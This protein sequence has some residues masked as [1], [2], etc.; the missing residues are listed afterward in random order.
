M[1]VGTFQYS[2]YG[3]LHGMEDPNSRRMS[4]SVVSPGTTNDVWKRVMPYIA[5][6]YHQICYNNWICRLCLNVWYRDSYARYWKKC[7][8]PSSC[9]ICNWF[10][11]PQLANQDRYHHNRCNSCLHGGW[12]GGE[13]VRVCSQVSAVSPT[14]TIL[15]ICRYLSQNHYRAQQNDTWWIILPSQLKSQIITKTNGCME[16]DSDESHYGIPFIILS[17]DTTW[18]HQAMLNDEQSNVRKGWP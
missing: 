10:Y 12:C 4:L 7:N 16:W 3:Q 6:I 8:T 17:N 11:R 5:H 9:V 1:R 15:S 2:T 13:K 14:S 18:E